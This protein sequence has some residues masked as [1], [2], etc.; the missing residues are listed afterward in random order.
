MG[1]GREPPL[2]ASN[3]AALKLS[4]F[5]RFIVNKHGEGRKNCGGNGKCYYACGT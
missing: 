2:V 3:S 5:E 1:L 4:L